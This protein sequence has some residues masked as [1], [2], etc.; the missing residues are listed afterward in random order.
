MCK[1]THA[2]ASTLKTHNNLLMNYFFHSPQTIS[3]HEPPHIQDVISMDICTLVN[4]YT[5]A[6]S[7]ESEFQDDKH[8]RLARQ[9]RQ[10]HKT[11]HKKAAAAP[12]KHKKTNNDDACAC[13]HTIS[14]SRLYSSFFSRISLGV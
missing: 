1:Q 3:P 9:W 2:A 13:L 12:H 5:L 6:R 10:Q 4:V 14:V 8:K 7:I 11:Q